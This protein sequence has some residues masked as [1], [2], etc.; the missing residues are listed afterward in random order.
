MAQNGDLKGVKALIKAG[1]HD[2][3]LIGDEYGRTALHWAS[4]KGHESCVRELV[5]AGA[6]LNVKNVKNHYFT[7]LD[8]AIT[9]RNQ[10]IGEY[11][12]SKG[13]VCSRQKYPEEW[14][15]MCLIF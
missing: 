5:L 8:D 9:A 6:K 13:A 3:N 7:A 10:A 12:R 14:K 1:E 15:G 2:L 4:G 11:L